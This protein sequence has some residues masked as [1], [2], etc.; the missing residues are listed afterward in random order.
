M[1]ALLPKDAVVEAEAI[2]DVVAVM[3]VAEIIDT[4]AD[5]YDRKVSGIDIGDTEL[6][7]VVDV[8]QRG[9][10]EV[11][12]VAAIGSQVQVVEEAW[13]EVIIPTEATEVRDEILCPLVRVHRVRQ[14]ARRLQAGVLAGRVRAINRAAAKLLI[15]ADGVGG[16]V[17][18]IWR[19]EGVVVDDVGILRG[20]VVLQNV[21]SHRTDLSRRND[22]PRKSRPA[23]PAVHYTRGGWVEDLA[24]IHRC[25]VA[26]IRAQHIVGLQKL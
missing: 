6:R 17:D 19:I 25:A 1:S 24:V 26:G 10:S 14:S 7:R 5:R 22:V 15:D 20:R 13:R 16:V 9:H 11:L 21:S 2:V 23:G 8:P 3:T 12:R 4:F 18:G